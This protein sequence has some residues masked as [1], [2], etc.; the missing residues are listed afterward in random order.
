MDIGSGGGKTIHA[1]YI[2]T[3][4]GKLYGIDYSKQAETCKVNIRQASVSD[5]PFPGNAFDIVTACQTHYFW[6]DLENDVKE[7]F[8][9]LKQDGKFMILAEL[10]N[11]NYHMKSCKTTEEMKQLFFISVEFYE[12]KNK[13]WLCIIGFK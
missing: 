13:G 5:I 7:V 3:E 6:S 8:R 10:Y 11:I 9:V 1:L 4:Y 2:I 12:N